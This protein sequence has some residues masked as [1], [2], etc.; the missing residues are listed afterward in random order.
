MIPVV[1]NMKKVILL[2]VLLTLNSCYLF[3]EK[4]IDFK[5]VNNSEM[6]ISDVKFYTSEQLNKV[7]FDSIAANKS[8][9][10]FLSMKDNQSD[11]SYILEF[12]R[13]D[14]KKEIQSAG[15]YTNGGSINSWIRFEVKSDTILV[16]Y[17]EF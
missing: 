3:K 15:Y 11:G 6:E 4:G 5:I 14:S 9:S 8:V 10:D 17:G 1:R 2:T 12:T 16:K 13:A 7:E